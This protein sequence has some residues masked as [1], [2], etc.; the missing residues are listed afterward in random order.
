[1]KLANDAKLIEYNYKPKITAF[2]DGGYQSSFV[3][4]PYKNFGLSAGVGVSVPIYDGHQRKMLQQQN[5][6]DLETKRKYLEQT[7]RQYQQQI[8]NIESQTTQYQKLLKI[9]GLFLE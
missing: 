7:H 3:H 5:Q 8:L 1:M 2:T 9:S 6:L 4:T